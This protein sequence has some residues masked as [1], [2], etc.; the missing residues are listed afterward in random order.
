MELQTI[1][2]VSKNYGI[3]A[4]MLRYYE[5]IGLI[6]NI[7]NDGNAYRFY[8]EA[9][10]K[11]LHSIILLRKLRISVIQIKKILDNQN[12]LKTVEIFE[13]NISELDEEITSL[14]TNGRYY[15]KSS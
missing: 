5:K 7:R 15:G 14:S 8:D 4:Q 3:S 6:Q 13:Q 11:Q 10:I 12:A 2:Q 9:T 1:S